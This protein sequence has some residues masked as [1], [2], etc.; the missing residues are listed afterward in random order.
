MGNVQKLCGEQ[1][2]RGGLS[3]IYFI[4]VE[5]LGKGGGRVFERAGGKGCGVGEVWRGLKWLKGVGGGW[6]A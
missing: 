3:R 1:G 2:V 6:Q 4:H 5:G